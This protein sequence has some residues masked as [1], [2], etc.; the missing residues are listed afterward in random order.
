MFMWFGPL[1]CV[2]MVEG[3]NADHT[4]LL[5]NVFYGDLLGLSLVHGV[6][7][8]SEALG[9]QLAVLMSEANHKWGTLKY[10]EVNLR[11]FNDCVFL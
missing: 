10:I 7:A 1:L 8:L 3:L 4:I 11:T 2:H 5:T 9:K 6:H